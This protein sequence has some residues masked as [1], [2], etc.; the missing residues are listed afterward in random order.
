MVVFITD[1]GCPFYYVFGIPC[2]TCGTTRALIC[3]F[4]LDIK[5]YLSYNPAAL[6]LLPLP[7][8]VAFDLHR[9]KRYALCTASVN[10]VFYLVRLARIF[11]N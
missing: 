5:G 2:P 9:Q 4:R 7:M 10:F 3:L 1:I 11:L 6:F 8:I